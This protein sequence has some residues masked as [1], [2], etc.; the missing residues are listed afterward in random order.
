MREIHWHPNNDEFLYFLT[1]QARMTVFADTG[2]SRTFDYR[3]G[4]VGYASVGYGHYIQN[5]GNE[6]VWFLETF[7]SDRF[8]SVSLSQMMAVTPQQLI[9]SNLHVGPEFLKTLSMSKMQCPVIPC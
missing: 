8:E 9:A 1:G 2:A 3:A 5:T 6:T 7:K 4:D